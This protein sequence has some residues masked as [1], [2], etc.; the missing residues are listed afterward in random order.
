MFLRSADEDRIEQVL[1]NLLD[2]AIRHSKKETD[3]SIHAKSIEADSKSVGQLII[4]DQGQGIDEQ[5]LP[6]IFDRFYKGR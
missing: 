3:I 1:T 4:Q 6:Y 5:S 2:N